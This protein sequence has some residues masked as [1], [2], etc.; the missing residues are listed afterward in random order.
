MCEYSFYS[1]SHFKLRSFING[2]GSIINM[3]GRDI[4]KTHYSSPNQ[5]D[6][7]AIRKDWELVGN[8]I[9]TAINSFSSEENNIRV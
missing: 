7:H 2:M 4:G 9:R 5:A 3:Y 8:D 1:K 6:S